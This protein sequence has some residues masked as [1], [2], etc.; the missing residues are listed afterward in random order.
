MIAFVGYDCVSDAPQCAAWCGVKLDQNLL[1]GILAVQRQMI[2][3]EDLIRGASLWADDE[4]Q[5]LQDV[6]R[7]CGMLSADQAAELEAMIHEKK[8]VAATYDLPPS[9]ADQPGEDTD[10]S[11]QATLD[12]TPSEE[13]ITELTNEPPSLWAT[14]SEVILG[15]P[16][17]SSEVYQPSS[18]PQALRFRKVRFHDKGGLGEIHVAV[19][20]ELPREV[21]LKE[22]K[23]RYANVHSSR[24][25]FAQE[26]RI[27]GALEHPG[28]VPVYG[29][30][31]YDDGQLYY[32]M[33]FIEGETLSKAIARYHR[34]ESSGM[35]PGEKR[36]AFRKLLDQFVDVCHV[37]NYAH[38]RGVIH[39]DIKP[40]N[41]MLG[42]YGETLVVDWGL[43]KRVDEEDIAGGDS[44]ETS[45]PVRI[46][47][48]STTLPGSVVG[49]P[50][51]M[52]PEQATGTNEGVGPCSDIY[53]LGA[54]LYRLLTGLFPF[55]GETAIEQVCQGDFKPP[56]EVARGVPPALESICLKAMAL[57]PEDRY[58]SAGDLASDVQRYLADEP[59]SVYRE[60]LLQQAAR[61]ARHHKVAV[62]T[63]SALLVT[64]LIGLTVWSEVESSRDR[65]ALKLVQEKVSEGEA[66]LD[67]GEFA[68]AQGFFREAEGLA[69]QRMALRT[70][71]VETRD[72]REKIEDVMATRKQFK[73]VSSAVESKI[74]DLRADAFGTD[75]PAA[76]A[77]G[78]E[79]RNMFLSSGWQA[80]LDQANDNATEG[81]DSKDV[82][83]FR[84]TMAEALV[85]LAR[86]EEL[87]A[88]A[89]KK[90]ESRRDAIRLLNEAEALAGPHWAISRMRVEL[91]RALGELELEKSEQV[92]LED[93][94][95]NAVID[96]M[97]QSILAQNNGDIP[98]AIEILKTALQAKPD[99]YF[100]H[101]QL[102]Y[103][104]HQLS[105]ARRDVLTRG[106]EYA[107]QA[108]RLR[109][110]ESQ[111]YA[112]KALLLGTLGKIEGEGGALDELL[113]AQSKDPDDYYVFQ[114]RGLT[115][116]KQAARS[117]DSRATAQELQKK[118]KFLDQ[119]ITEFEQSFD[120]KP[121]V[122]TIV[123]IGEARA[124]K[125]RFLEARGGIEGERRAA[126]ERDLSIASYTK[127]LD[128]FPREVRALRGLAKVRMES[129]EFE[130]ALQNLL[131][132][133]R[134]KPNSW[135]T[136]R[137]LGTLIER[138]ALRDGALGRPEQATEKLQRAEKHLDR[139]L[140][141]AP[142]AVD[143]RFGRGRVRYHLWQQEMQSTRKQ[144]DVPDLA[145]S[146][147]GA[148]N[149]LQSVAD[150]RSVD[151]LVGLLGSDRLADLYKMLG[152]LKSYNQKNEDALGDYLRA[153]EYGYA[154]PRLRLRLGWTQLTD[155]V[156]VRNQFD[157]L[158]NRHQ[159]TDRQQAE[160]HNG[161]GFARA[162][163]G[164][165]QGAI[166][167]AQAAVALAE[168]MKNREAWQVL[169]SA[170][171]IYALC[172]EIAE[173][174]KLD[175]VLAEQRAKRAVD[176]LR[177]AKQ[178]G[179][180]NTQLIRSDRAFVPLLRSKDFQQL[181][182][183]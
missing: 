93:L 34:S 163:L 16:D 59:V 43:A 175:P 135:E 44:K 177:E 85:L 82:Q 13:H 80:R 48:A 120:K 154:D 129:G 73:D 181:L 57:A 89:D 104:H 91:Y 90:D 114:V 56:R 127:A 115:R 76:Q 125:A 143:A 166:K 79:I 182:Q 30:G 12:H 49:T 46:R 161:R 97:L 119:A 108:I 45:R 35:N 137:W 179:L 52:S 118:G 86:A 77:L 140:R 99:E 103:L 152:D 50:A 64:L 6:L 113:Q 121:L 29:L 126:K 8:S 87:G 130:A 128:E 75:F 160:A 134:I 107:D 100:V 47:N 60:P 124:E 98:R 84:E 173:R 131:Q 168:K 42:P 123:N 106:I 94:V 170:A 167:D 139:A 133:Q 39:R 102:A 150:T 32:A 38:D 61:V 142:G 136:Q 116:L 15:A 33:R 51:Y 176:L 146:S 20:R 2:S 3:P 88:A 81:I 96:W 159:L 19:D 69:E 138:Q 74:D 155:M 95:P 148:M 153:L 157:A 162:M 183:D 92:R 25:R 4:E 65:T 158:L 147:L 24:E 169:F 21:A 63:V 36:L 37:I 164:E 1:F 105:F 5:S 149:D 72:R 144:A 10:Q 7:Q 67:E 18:D 117:D 145:G 112:L 111:P 151:A 17:A 31:Q 71:Y 180:S 178:R 70:L 26:A 174:E 9:A 41:I 141:L 132:A 78:Q 172:A 165:D 66:A 156:S 109:P 110:Q 122:E 62:S 14:P 40:D 55:Q 23:P 22:I 68:K 53:S 58:P 11:M 54:T 27:T 28:I 101:L 83:A 171:G